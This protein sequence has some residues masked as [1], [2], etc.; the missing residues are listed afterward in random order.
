MLSYSN[1]K[2]AEQL[3]NQIST[4]DKAFACVLAAALISGKEGRGDDSL[5][6]WTLAYSKMRARGWSPAV[7]KDTAEDLMSLLDSAPK[8]KE[9]IIESLNADN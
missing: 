2:A 4:E 9:L 5:A 6:R 3:L 7:I 1:R 8:L